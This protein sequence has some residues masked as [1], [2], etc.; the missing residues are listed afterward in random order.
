MKSIQQI[1]S[2]VQM[3]ISSPTT[4][5]SP[6]VIPILDA[7][8]LDENLRNRVLATS[9]LNRHQIDGHL[10]IIPLKHFCRLL[11]ELTELTGDAMFG[12]NVGASLHA[13]HLGLIGQLAI[14]SQNLAEAF[15]SMSN[16]FSFFRAKR[17][18]VFIKKKIYTGFLMRSV[19][20]GSQITN[21]M[22]T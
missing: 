22:R 11:D 15:D 3:K 19:T 20:T 6:L 1:G 5:L 18:L 12:I 17:I 14:T 9:S 13:A 16:H 2:Y 4:T 7:A 10:N 21:K 8:D